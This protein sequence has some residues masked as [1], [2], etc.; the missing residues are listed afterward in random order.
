MTDYLESAADYVRTR[1]DQQG[2]FVES[3]EDEPTLEAARFAAEVLATAG[4]LDVGQFANALQRCDRSWG[5]SMT[6]TGEGPELGATYYGWRLRQ[7]MGHGGERNKAS[8]WIVRQ[9]FDAENEVTVDVDDVFYAVRA[10]DIVG[11]ELA[12][13]QQESL[14][15][16]LASCQSPDG[17]YALLPG[18]PSDIERTYCAVATLLWLNTET[19]K[20]RARNEREWIQACAND[21]CIKGAPDVL[22]AN[23]ATAYWGSRSAEL[24]DIAWPWDSVRDLALRGQRSDGGF[25]IGEGSTLWET[26]CGVR[27]IRMADCHRTQRA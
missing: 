3:G 2:N 21:G 26:Y 9:V 1:V 25:G 8:S 20:T 13:E 27:L 15:K 22:D 10:L 11:A 6:L 17:G 5:F 7:L 12:P 4:S 23:L 19:D 16:F 18:N 14:R 24:L